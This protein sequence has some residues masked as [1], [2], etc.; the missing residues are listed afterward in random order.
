MGKREEIVEKLVTA[1]I[2]NEIT[3]IAVANL[4]LEEGGKD[5]LDMQCNFSALMYI[6]TEQQAIIGKLLEELIQAQVLNGS[7]LERVTDIYGNRDTLEPVYSDLYKRFAW[8]FIQIKEALQEKNQNS[9]ESWNP[10]TNLEP[11]DDTD[12]A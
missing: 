9:P 8:Y 5:F 12:P 10:S 6:I 11:T 7:S 4:V 1:G 3:A 2:G